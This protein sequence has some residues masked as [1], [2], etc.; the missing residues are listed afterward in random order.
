MKTK[1]ILILLCF[2]FI[3]SVFTACSSEAPSEAAENK[4]EPKSISSIPKDDT[5]FK[6]CY[7][8]S[9]SLNPYECETQNNQTLSQ[10]VFE[11]LFS[12]D[13]HYKASCSIAKK[14][15]YT[16]SKILRVT[17]QDGLI[18]SDGTSLTADDITYS[19]RKAV[20]SSY[21]GSSLSGIS[22][23][24]AVSSDTVDFQLEYPNS[25]AHNLLI[26]PIMSQSSETS[27]YPI[28]SG[29]YY[30]ANEKEEIVLK[31]NEKNGFSPYLTT[32][33]LENIPASDSIDNAVNIGNVNLIF[34]DLSRD[35][36]K[37]IDSN[38][39]LVN[40][41]NLVYIGINNK[42]GLGANSYIRKAI[43]S[44]I[45]RELLT[46]SAYSGFAKTAKT[47]FNPE[48]E[49]STTEI[50][51]KTANTNAAKQAMLQSGLSNFTIS[52]LVNGTN[53]DR[54]TCA[55]LIKQQ[56]ENVGF[57]VHLSVADTYKSYEKQIRKEKFD[58]YLGEIKI[59]PDMSL[60]HF[61]S[62]KGSARFGINPKK[63]AAAKEYN[64][65]INGETDLGSFLISFSEEMPFIPVLYRQG[66]IC[67]SK[68]MNGDMQGTS[69]DCFKNIENWYFISE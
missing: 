53:E 33:H 55:K 14:Y 31:A 25:Y 15:E 28:G 44:A 23:C 51:E 10:L 20:K 64:K 21:W 4:T 16:N 7:T 62:S 27:E 58:L 61:F 67:F 59:T 46:K 34:R 35:S 57:K 29:R 24:Y 38:Y 42:V 3:V 48:F 43:N 66:M 41:N 18:F 52:L 37:K 60:Q 68:E 32:I 13:E 5:S 6:L 50:F 19:F 12:I 39:K 63:S 56:L 26:F 69:T 40:M 17:I 47:I 65:Y 2:A 54:V 22:S 9:D 11:S 30:F 36:A 8:Q 49:L 45:D 1:S